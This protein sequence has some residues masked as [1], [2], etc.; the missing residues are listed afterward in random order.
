MNHIHHSLL[1]CELQISGD[2][3]NELRFHEPLDHGYNGVSTCFRHRISSFWLLILRYI[4]YMPHSTL[5][6]FNCKRSMYCQRH[7]CT[8]PQS[9]GSVGR[10]AADPWPLPIQRALYHPA[11]CMHLH[12]PSLK[13]VWCTLHQQ[14][15]SLKHSSM[16][17]LKPLRVVL[18]APC[19]ERDSTTAA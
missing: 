11:P 12:T 17:S 1:P 2:C 19:E 4:Y 8:A 14:S 16:N 13:G 18:R 3:A 9:V 5:Q 15:A 7:L 10:G 6:T